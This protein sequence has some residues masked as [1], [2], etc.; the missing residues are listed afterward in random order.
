MHCRRSVVGIHSK[1]AVPGKGV[2]WP[3][4]VIKTITRLPR[5][6][7]FT[8]RLPFAISIKRTHFT[9]W[10]ARAHSRHRRQQQN[11]PK[12]NRNV[13]TPRGPTET[14]NRPTA[15]TKSFDRIVAPFHFYFNSSF[16]LF[17]FFAFRFN[18]STHLTNICVSH[19]GT[20]VNGLRPFGIAVASEIN[21]I[22]VNA[23]SRCAARCYRR[24][25][26]P[27]SVTLK[28]KR[29]HIHTASPY[30]YHDCPTSVVHSIWLPHRHDRECACSIIWCVAV[31]AFRAER[32][33]FLALKINRFAFGPFIK[34]RKNEK[35]SA[36][37]VCCSI[38][39]YRPSN[40]TTALGIE[41]VRVV[42]CVCF[43][44]SECPESH[45][46]YS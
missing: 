15:F 33:I 41:R 46:W 2:Q 17:L 11:D 14:K 23:A 19:C 45:L 24:S 3:A 43:E 36:N 4:H 9:Q 28:L 25:R 37:Y 38:I 30:H 16:D 18:S 44:V 31:C 21:A 10:A 1:H 32:T 42:I 5:E 7:V 22:A 8:F 29:T 34:R 39:V 35:T 6:N 20:H 12:Q 26:A 13:K 27:Q 40:N